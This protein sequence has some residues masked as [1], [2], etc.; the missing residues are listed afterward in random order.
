LS[1][2]GIGLKKLLFLLIF[3]L[4][5]F[6]SFKLY[7]YPILGKALSQSQVLEILKTPFSIVSENKVVIFDNHKKEEVPFLD[8][9]DPGTNGY[10]ALYNKMGS[11]VEVYHQNKLLTSF[12]NRFVY[13]HIAYPYLFLFSSD[14]CKAEIYQLSSLKNALGS[15]HTK[16]IISAWSSSPK[17]EYAILG[18]LSGQYHIFAPSAHNFKTYT[19]KESRL[20]YV[21]GVE[22]SDD[23]SY[24]VLGSLHPEVFVLGNVYQGISKIYH[25]PSTG[26]KQQ[27]IIHLN[28]YMLLEKTGGVFIF[29]KNKKKLYQ[30]QASDYYRFYSGIE[31]EKNKQSFLALLFKK[32]N[33]TRVELFLNHL[34]LYTVFINTPSIPQFYQEENKSFVIFEEGGIEL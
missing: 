13:P 25:L 12:Q 29:D 19:L 31:F 22:I 32:G 6:F 34:Y 5:C 27:K 28:S 20:N 17:G 16:D 24:S 1:L 21:K 4:C 11:L 14:L 3:Y 7:D 18:D 15:I 23:G 10:F 26:R 33:E 8:Y 30:H 2:R 9:I